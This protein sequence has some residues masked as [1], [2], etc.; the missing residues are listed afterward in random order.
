MNKAGMEKKILR[1][2]FL[3]SIIFTVLEIVMSIFLHS[4]SVL[5]DGIYD[6]AELILMGPFLV[7]IPLLYKP[8][9]EKRPYG[10]SQFE[11]LFLLIKYGILLFITVHLVIANIKLIYHGGHTV[12]AG[13]VAIFEAVLAVGS[14]FM[15]FLLQYFSRKYVS[16]TVQA[17]LFM[18]KVDII[19]S[20]GITAAFLAQLFLGR[21]SFAFLTPY[22]DSGVA[23]VMACFLVKEPVISMFQN[24]KNLVLLA[25][26]EEVRDRIHKTVEASLQ[27][28]P[29]QMTFLDVIQTGRKTWIEVYMESPNQTFHAE[30]LY[31][32]RNQIRRKLRKDF[33]Q[34]YVELIPDLP[35]K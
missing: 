4:Y 34:L 35:D 33:D 25:P 11:S 19:G 6:G 23:V 9:S 7:L 22:M 13:G 21:T 1:I 3:G 15:Y 12:D 5:M 10:F 17:E 14:V 24:L 31:Q 8:V 28:Y 18:W 20:I 32:I 2:S 26:P 29:Y 30:H 16:L 27:E